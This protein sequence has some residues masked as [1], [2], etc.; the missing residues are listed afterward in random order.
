MKIV[1]APDSFKGSL[2]S[3]QVIEGIEAA[4]RRNFPDCEIAKFPIADGGEGT[5]DAL[6]GVTGGKFCYE[7]V[8][9]SMG[10]P[11]CAKYGVIH[12]DT[13]VIEMAA[14]NGLP[15]VPREK[16]DLFRAAS[17]GTGQLIRKALEDGYRKIII[18]VGGSA[19]NDGGLGAM[20]A[21]GMEFLDKNGNLLEPVGKSLG[22]VA[23]YRTE[24]LCEGLLEAEL[25]VMCDVDNPLVGPQGATYVYGPQKGGTRESLEALEAGM[26]NYADVILRKSGVALHDMPGAGAAG[27][28][29]AALFAFAGA[30]LRSGISVVLEASGF[31][32]SLRDADLVITGEG[33]LDSQSV[34]GKVVHGVGT[35]CKRHG[36]PVV[37]VVG[38]MISGAEEIYDHGVNSVMTIVNG[39]MR[40]DQAVD[41]AAGLLVDSADRMFR[42]M[43][44]GK[45]LRP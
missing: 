5:V 11:I 37:A 12:G 8:K 16:R 30:K 31:E 27:G 41:H 35:V 25:V 2:T 9:D 34:R 1:L 33:C 45:A 3:A 29:S 24:H 18:A 10:D 44:I 36:V 42:L 38:S 4:A 23:D 22:A 28:I 21:L 7:T 20:A 39:V 14:A 17:Y 32:E 40:L 15:L 6:V 19:T 26:R 43:K 13:A